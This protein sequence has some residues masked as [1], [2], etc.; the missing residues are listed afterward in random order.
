MDSDT[1]N[2]WLDVRSLTFI[3]VE[4][5]IKRENLPCVLNKFFIEDK[6]LLNGIQYFVPINGY[7]KKN[8]NL[9]EKLVSQSHEELE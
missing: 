5:S 8:L 7:R 1:L 2:K 4:N 3:Y 6:L 9:Q